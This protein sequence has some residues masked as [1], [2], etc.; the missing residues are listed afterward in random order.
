MQTFRGIW[1][2]SGLE[3]EDA[4]QHLVIVFAARLQGPSPFDPSRT[5]LKN[6]LFLL[7]RSVLAN[8]A[9]KRANRTTV[10]DVLAPHE[11]HHCE[12]LDEEGLIRRRS[13]FERTLGYWE[14]AKLDSSE[15]AAKLLKGRR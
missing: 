15:D 6:Y 9:E 14:R 3:L 4:V 1:L 8:Q 7:A 2:A 11:L 13:S 10:L 5:S 12:T